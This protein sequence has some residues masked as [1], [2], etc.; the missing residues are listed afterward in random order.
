MEPGCCVDELPCDEVPCV[1]PLE[2]CCDELP[3]VE[4]SDAPVALRLPPNVE[5][6][7]LIPL[8]DPVV[9]GEPTL[10]APAPLCCIAMVRLSDSTI[11]SRRA[12]RA[13]NDPD[14]VVGEL[15]VPLLPKVP[16]LLLEL[17]KV[18]EP[19]I[20]ELWPSPPLDDEPV[21]DWPSVPGWPA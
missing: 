19:P 2:R 14:P 16:L 18:P 7:E 9:P 10:L 17:P 12:T 13:S 21:L 3:V 5:L 1:E 8:C 15:N 20:V 4:L 6:P 11:C